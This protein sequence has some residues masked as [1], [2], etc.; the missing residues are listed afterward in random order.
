[1]PTYILD[2]AILP[3]FSFPYR[4]QTSSILIVYHS[5]DSGNS[6]ISRN[7]GSNKDWKIGKGILPL[8]KHLAMVLNDLPAGV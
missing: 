1:M 4:Y 5:Y 6:K 2:E 3:N 8:G 7:G